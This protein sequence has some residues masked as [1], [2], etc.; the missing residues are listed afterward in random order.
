[1]AEEMSGL[2]DA[3]GRPIPRSVLAQMRAE[4]SGTDAIE[5]RPPFAGHF[6]TRMRPELL[7]G[8][9]RAADNGS[10]LEWRIVQEEIEEMYP[11]YHAVLSKR[12]RGVCQLPITARPASDDAEHVKH[13]AFVTD[14]L[15]TGV[16]ESALFD[17]T[18]AIGKG[19]S[20]TEI[21][22]ETK[23][24]CVRPKELLFRE[25][26]FFELSWRDGD[27]IWL[28]TGAANASSETL[29]GFADLAP[30]KFI[31]HR[32]KAKSGLTIRAGLTRIVA[33][34]WMYS[35]FTLRDWA[36]FTQAYGMPI[37]LG[38]YGPEAS[39]TDKSILWRAVSSIAGDVAAM[40][41]KSMEVEFPTIADRKGGSELYEKRLDWLDRTVSKVVLGG[42]AGTDAI[43]GGH[44]V[45]KE[46]RDVEQ[47]VERFDAGKLSNTLTRQVI[48]SMIAFTFG[49][50]EAYPILHIGQPDQVPLNE[51]IQGAAAM[52]PLGLKV[53][54]DDVRERLGLAA[55]EGDDEVLAPP[56]PAAAPGAAGKLLPAVKPDDATADMQTARRYLGRL[57]TLQA[58]AAPELVE[59]LT[60]RVAGEAAGALAGMTGA[61]RHAFDQATDLHDLAHRLSRLELP[62]KEFA[63]AMARGMALA[64]IVGQADLLD[65][66]GVRRH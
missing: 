36:L 11:H 6:A 29:G 44:A 49:P 20:V 64:Q 1:M 33:F 63:E 39:Q 60:A 35:M 53:R 23:P 45:G 19:G 57:I 59:Q 61:V 52:I 9:I 26:R 14:W 62:Q 32:H 2:L 24:G 50:Q 34:L 38:R 16:L 46:H 42:T 56:A 47:D 4:I 41:P 17:I 28:R 58:E 30:H 31:Q 12:R 7:G 10:S 37:R 66:I 48:Q 15:K 25:W 43:A 18:D 27:T 22:W 21:V 54:A 8:I 65:E 3:D 5:G 51:F 40:I 55:P 13:A